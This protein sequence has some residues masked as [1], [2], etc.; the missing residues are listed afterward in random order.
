MRGVDNLFDGIRLQQEVRD[1]EMAAGDGGA[2]GQVQE[3]LL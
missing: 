1:Q 3:E 2:Y